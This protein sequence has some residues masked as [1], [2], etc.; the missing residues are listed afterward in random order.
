MNKSLSETLE[1]Y[2]STVRDC[3]HT[4]NNRVVTLYTSNNERTVMMM[5]AAV[6]P[7]MME[8]ECL[9]SY[10]LIINIYIDIKLNWFPTSGDI[11]A[12]AAFEYGDVLHTS[13][14]EPTFSVL[15]PESHFDFCIPI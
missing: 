14:W 8:L 1:S 3:H 11:S 5:D 13:K 12:S 9:L 15:F 7:K 10:H 2:F 6:V 4:Y